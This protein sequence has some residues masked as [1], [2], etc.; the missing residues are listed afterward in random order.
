MICPVSQ[1]VSAR[2][3][4]RV[5]IWCWPMRTAAP[6]SLIFFFCGILEIIKN[7]GTFLFVCFLG[8][9]IPGN[10]VCGS[11]ATSCLMKSSCV[12]FCLPPV[13]L[14]LLEFCVNFWDMI[15]FFF[16]EGTKT[17]V[18]LAET[19]DWAAVQE[20]GVA[21]IPNNVPA[22]LLRVWK[23]SWEHRRR[24][25]CRC[26]RRRSAPAVEMLLLILFFLS[27]FL[28]SPPTIRKLVGGRVWKHFE[29]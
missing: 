15:F 27:F 17:C 18:D 21:S 6:V 29:S 3:N 1:S 14:I 22:F 26:R 19:S 16:G 20:A 11:A 28:W 4:V 12:R 10:P 7:S 23:G 13:L 8:Q 5:I 25:R 2:V 9:Q 24:R